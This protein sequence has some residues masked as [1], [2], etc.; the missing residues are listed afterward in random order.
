MAADCNSLKKGLKQ[1]TNLKKKRKMLG[2]LI[3]QCPDDPMVNYKYAL[4]LERFRKYDKALAYYQKTISLSPKMGKAY[5]GAGDVYIYLGLLDE[6]IEAYRNAVRLI[7]ESRRA[8]ARLGR[9][10]IKRKALKGDVV[11]VGEFIKMMDHRGKIP[12]NMPLLLTGPILQ[13]KIAFVGNTA[14][15]LPTGIRQLAAIGQAMQN[16]VLKYMR[17]EIAT[18]VDSSYGSSQMALAES[19]KRAKMLKD[20]LVGNFMIAPDRIELSWY[21]DTQPLEAGEFVGSRSLNNRVE[22]KRLLE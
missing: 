13:Y 18:F 5:V 9:L 2:V 15:L 6:A 1:E 17:F 19:E 10:E 8:K 22:I 3:A 14:Q 11:R 4:S 7:P 16:D 21:G 12:S 20:Q